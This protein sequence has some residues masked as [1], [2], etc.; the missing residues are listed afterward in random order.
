V[1]VGAPLLEAKTYYRLGYAMWQVRG[2]RVRLECQP[3]TTADKE[4]LPQLPK[5][6]AS[7]FRGL[8]DGTSIG[9][10]HV[11]AMEFSV[12]GRLFPLGMGYRIGLPG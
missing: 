7:F 2:W 8:L 9:F 4:N 12:E 6:G 10:V 1:L 3:K 11:L 5:R